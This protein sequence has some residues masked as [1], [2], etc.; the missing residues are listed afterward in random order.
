MRYDTVRICIRRSRDA[1][2]YATSE[3]TFPIKGKNSGI[4]PFL[5]LKKADLQCR[6]QQRDIFFAFPLF[7]CARAQK[8]K[9]M[10]MEHA[11]TKTRTE[12]FSFFCP[13]L[14]PAA[15]LFLPDK[16]RTHHE[17]CSNN[18]FIIL[19]LHTAVSVHKNKSH[20]IWNA[21]RS[22][23]FLLK[24]KGSSKNKKSHPC[25]WIKNKAPERINIDIQYSLD[26]ARVAKVA[27]NSIALVSIAECNKILSLL[28]GKNQ[29]RCT[30]PGAESW[31][32]FNKHANAR[33][34][35]LLRL[36]CRRLG[37]KCVWK[38]CI[39]QECWKILNS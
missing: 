35:H 37:A 36:S 28:S 15:A 20:N 27:A 21:K 29:R 33:K 19:F 30:S 24:F 26:Y 8:K 13:F 11:H 10:G 34:L 6:R 14:S 39:R 38:L 4:S 31:R 25:Q 18:F 3:T 32:H 17:P 16:I 1:C 9:T 2:G 22:A 7:R 23:L 5:R 12:P